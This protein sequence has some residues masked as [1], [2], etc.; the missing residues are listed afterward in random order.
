MFWLLCFCFS[1]LKMGN[2]DSVFDFMFTQY[3]TGGRGGGRGGE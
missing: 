3:V 1:R 2:I